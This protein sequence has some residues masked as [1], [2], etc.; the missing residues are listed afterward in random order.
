[1]S[2]APINPLMLETSQTQSQENPMDIDGPTP[3]TSSIAPAPNTAPA[4]NH[5]LEPPIAPLQHQHLLYTNPQPWFHRTWLFHTIP[6]KTKHLVSGDWRLDMATNNIQLDPVIREG[7]EVSSTSTTAKQRLIEQTSS[8][9]QKKWIV[10][11]KFPGVLA[12]MSEHPPF[13]ATAAMK[14]MFQI[15]LNLL[16]IDTFLHFGHGQTPSLPFRLGLPTAPTDF[17][18][19]TQAG[20]RVC[21]PRHVTG[22]QYLTLYQFQRAFSNWPKILSESH[23]IYKNVQQN[24]QYKPREGPTQPLAL[25]VIKNLTEYHNTSPEFYKIVQ[26]FR[27][28]AAALALLS[29]YASIHK[30]AP[31]HPNPTSNRDLK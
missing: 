12:M 26:A 24:F 15:Y 31:S 4:P 16:T 6:W 30:S 7:L 10:D 17:Q 21:S 28:S 14:T 5:P 23:E 3:S 13:N 19:T 25:T 22:Q 8:N 2:T 11:P 29:P 1:M 27:I 20:K 18:L 9:E